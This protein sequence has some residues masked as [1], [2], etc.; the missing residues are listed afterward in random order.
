M[1]AQG[2]LRQQDAGWLVL[3]DATSRPPPAQGPSDCK[4]R[5]VPWTHQSPATHLDQQGHRAWA[6]APAAPLP[7][8]GFIAL[9]SVIINTAKHSHSL[10]ENRLKNLVSKTFEKCIKFTLKKKLKILPNYSTAVRKLLCYPHGTK[11][12]PQSN[13]DN[14]CILALSQESKIAC[15]SLAERKVKR[16]KFVMWLLNYTDEY[17]YRA[18]FQNRN[19][20]V[21]HYLIKNS[22]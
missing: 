16:L 22:T 15:T 6:L 1:S 17:I 10:N 13:K 11:E 19:L 21:K 12:V 20:A 4:W 7:G 18:N 14:C 8:F 9:L 5:G 2:N 3:P